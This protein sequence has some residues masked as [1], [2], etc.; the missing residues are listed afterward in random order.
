MDRPDEAGT[1]GERCGPAAL[2]QRRVLA[3]TEQVPGVEIVAWVPGGVDPRVGEGQ[4][5]LRIILGPEHVTNRVRETG[6]AW[7][8]GTGERT[9]WQLLVRWNRS[10]W[11]RT[12]GAV[13]HREAVDRDLLPEQ[14]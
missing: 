14:D 8:F 3:P 12:P 7:T 4:E 13:A 5:C 1:T 10:G 11:S 2:D 9:G 6:P